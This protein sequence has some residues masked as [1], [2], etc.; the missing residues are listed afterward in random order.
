MH[1]GILSYNSNRKGDRGKP[2]LTSE[3]TIKGDLEGW[4]ILKDLAL[5][6]SEQK[7]TKP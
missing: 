6:G 1:S 5:N 3:E 4:N 2:K 7:T